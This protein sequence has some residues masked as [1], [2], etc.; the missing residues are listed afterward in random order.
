MKTQ[1]LPNYNTNSAQMKIQILVKYTEE[2]WRLVLCP[3]YPWSSLI[4]RFQ[5]LVAD[6]NWRQRSSKI[7]FI[8]L[9]SAMWHFEN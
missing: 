2:W 5:S 6:S 4:P 1:M 7:S 8:P 3:S 9:L